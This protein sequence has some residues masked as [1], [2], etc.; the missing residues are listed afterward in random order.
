MQPRKFYLVHR[1]AIN[2]TMSTTEKKSAILRP[3][4]RLLYQMGD[5]VHV[6]DKNMVL[7]ATHL[8][9]DSFYGKP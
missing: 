3:L 8:F 7:H 1:P 2:V 9:V 4:T 5:S 6:P